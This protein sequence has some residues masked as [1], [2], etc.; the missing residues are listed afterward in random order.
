M[1]GI[2]AW[3][4]YNRESLLRCFRLLICVIFTYHTSEKVVALMIFVYF[5]IEFYIYI[6]GTI[7]AVFR[8]KYYL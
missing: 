2:P 4:L 6:S 7:I 8:V 3:T 1:S 5:L